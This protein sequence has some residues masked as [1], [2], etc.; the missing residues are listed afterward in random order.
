MEGGGSTP[1][2]PASGKLDNGTFDPAKGLTGWTQYFDGTGSAAAQ[3]GELAVALTGTG[4][5][6]YSAQVDYANLKLVKAK[7]IRW[8]LQPAPMWTV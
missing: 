3:D 6:N 1:V 4:T 7:R 8:L 5:A 2:E